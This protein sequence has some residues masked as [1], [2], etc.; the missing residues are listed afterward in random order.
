MYDEILSEFRMYLDENFKTNEEDNTGK[1][2][3]SDMNQFFRYFYETFDEIPDQISIAYVNEYKNYLLNTKGFKFSTINRKIAALST[4]EN[5]LIDVGKQ[6]TKSVKKKDFFK[7]TLPFITSNMLPK[8]TIKKLILRTGNTNIRDY[9][10]VLLANEGGLRVSE[11]INIQ[12]ERDIKIDMRTIVI[13]GKGNKIREIIITDQ[14]YDALEEYL[15]FR[16]NKLN[17]RKNKYLII[18]NESAN[19]GKHIDRTLINK[20][21]KKYCNY[22]NEKTINP[23]VIR[24]F[25]ATKKYENGYTDIMLKKILGQSSNVTERYCHTG[26][27]NLIEKQK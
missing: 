23:H 11:I 6:Q 25:F 4:F 7:I 3:M 18:S 22:I 12:V 15:K 26:N 5:F 19:T 24:H 27:E 1:A 2:Y 8:K 13:I 9:M 14:L 21:L 17:G 10:I 20:T 16:E